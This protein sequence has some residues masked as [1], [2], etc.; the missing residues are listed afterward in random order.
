MRERAERGETVNKK[1]PRVGLSNKAE[2]TGGHP[3]K[4]LNRT[5]QVGKEMTSNFAR[6]NSNSAHL[7]RK[8]KNA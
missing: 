5:G 2:D 4:V 1:F 7:V 6:R 3:D 8:P